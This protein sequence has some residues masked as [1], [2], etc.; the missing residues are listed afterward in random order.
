MMNGLKK[1]RVR[2]KPKKKGRS[3]HTKDV[4][5]STGNG[6]SGKSLTL[7]SNIQSAL[8]TECG[9]SQSNIKKIGLYN[10]ST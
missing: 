4:E 5:N 9:M 3:Q 1:N 6:E 7:S 10:Q 8:C 2:E